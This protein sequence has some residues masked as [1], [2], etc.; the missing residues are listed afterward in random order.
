VCP[1]DANGLVPTSNLPGSVSDIIEVANFAALPSTGDPLKRYVTTD[2]NKL[3][4]WSGS[5]Y[6]EISASLVLGTTAGTAFDGA[7]G[8]TNTNNIALKQDQLTFA[9]LSGLTLTTVGTTKSLAIDLL[10]TMVETSFDDNEIMLIQ[11][12]N[13]D[14]CRMTKQQLQSSINTNTEYNNG[15]NITIDSNNDINLDST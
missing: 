12:T 10:K 11:K 2:N 13:G 4:R 8:Q 5:A 15:D 1:L 7:S 14:L 6:F 3:Y 9:N